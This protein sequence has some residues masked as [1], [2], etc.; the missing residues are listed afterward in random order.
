MKGLG[1]ALMILGV[2]VI[3]LGLFGVGGGGYTIKSLTF[4]G[5]VMAVGG[6]LLYRHNRAKTVGG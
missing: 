3:V 5:V 2:V 6:F 1:F 4:V